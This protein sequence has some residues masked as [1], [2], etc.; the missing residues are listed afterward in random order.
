MELEGIHDGTSPE[1]GN[2]GV[3]PDGLPLDVPGEGSGGEPDGEEL[4]T[5]KGAE[6]G[7]VEGEG[8]H[9]EGDGEPHDKFAEPG[10]V[11][12]L[13]TIFNMMNSLLGAGILGVPGSM[14]YCG[15]VPSAIILLLV[16]TLAYIATVLTLRLQKR[17]NAKGLDDLCRIVL[18]KGGSIF[19]SVVTILFCISCL[20]AYIV[21]GTDSLLSFIRLGGG[22]VNNTWQR[23]LIVLAYSIILP[24]MLTLPRSIKFLGPFS[25]GCVIAILY[26]IAV[27][28]YKA[29]ITF[30]TDGINTNV[31]V[32]K[33]DI[34]VFTAI[35]VFGLAY[36]LPVTVLPII[37][38]YNKELKKREFAV[39]CSI[40]LTTVF[41]LSSGVIGYLL[42]GPDAKDNILLSYPDKDIP[43]LISRVGFF[44]V[45]SVSYP[46][47]AQTLLCSASDLIFHI[48][49]HGELLTWQRAIVIAIANVPPILIAM[50]LPTAGPAL[51]IA[52]AFGGSL[53]DFFCPAF[54]WFKLSNQKWFHWHNILSLLFAL[55]GI[56]A[57]V[58][59]TV[60]A[61]MDA[62]KAFS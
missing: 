56:V 22:T 38:S 16:G 62:I 43:I 31:V 53:I 40:L 52:G 7:D 27:L 10:R 54:M 51:S 59:S 37:G 11:R 34:G 57:T 46:C 29:A 44:I 26:Y 60:I 2:S 13:P 50:F 33:G 4:P 42:R 45:V 24:G 55:F 49:N 35:S 19:L 15:V 9:G 30:P 28:I 17:T 47:L 25:F 32:A 12:R 8:E 14:Q 1:G 48:N 20:V 21:I 41:T 39:L 58:I 61:I 18:G 6:G 3:D 5:D 23:P 36:A